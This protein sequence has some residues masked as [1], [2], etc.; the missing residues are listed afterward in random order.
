MKIFGSQNLELLTHSNILLGIVNFS[1]AIRSLQKKFG[2][3]S[4]KKNVKMSIEIGHNFELGRML[5]V[6]WFNTVLQKYKSGFAVK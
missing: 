5:K 4:R 1:H 2:C 3:D 6:Q